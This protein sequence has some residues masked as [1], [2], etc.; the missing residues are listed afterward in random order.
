[1][2]LLGVH[3][4]YLFKPS[5]ARLELLRSRSPSVDV[6][7]GNAQLTRDNEVHAEVCLRVLPSANGKPAVSR[8]PLQTAIASGSQDGADPEQV[9][10]RASEE[11]AGSRGVQ[12]VTAATSSVQTP[13]EIMTLRRIRKQSDERTPVGVRH[14][15]NANF[16]LVGYAPSPSR[17]AKNVMTLIASPLETLLKGLLPS[18]E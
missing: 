15:V 12:N 8:E 2:L 1:M 18:G 6:Q 4:D 10:S 5:K 7:I 11:A 17:T 16:R 3:Y 14:Q 9:S 13:C